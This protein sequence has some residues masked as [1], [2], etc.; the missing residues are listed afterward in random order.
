M[1]PGRR[2]GGL[3]AKKHASEIEQELKISLTREDLEKVF[4]SFAKDVKKTDIRHKF[5]P[6][7]YY[8]TED[9]AMQA[10]GVSLRVQYKPGKNGTLGSYEQTVKF[11]LTPDG[12]ADAEALY[13]KECKDMLDKNRPDMARVADPEAVQ[14]IKPFK[15]KELKH[16][17][18]AAIERRYFN[19]A[20]GKGKKRGEVELA[21]DVGKI[22]LPDAAGVEQPLAEIEIEIKKGS[23]KAIAAIK[24]KIFK[25]APGARVQREDKSAQG[26]RL[27]RTA[28]KQAKNL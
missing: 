6:R 19:V 26:S 8:D 13:R 12:A 25:I 1:L 24:E 9:L 27:Y 14:V 18:T 16:I 11:A 4:A 28:C 10:A 7:D 3:L 5:L 20:A 15:N 23:P 17:F 22:T 2:E 21:F